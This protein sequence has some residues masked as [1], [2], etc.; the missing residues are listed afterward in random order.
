MSDIEEN[1]CEGCDECNPGI[2][3]ATTAVD[4]IDSL[5][6]GLSANPRYI[7]EGHAWS[8]VQSILGSL[9]SN[10][11]TAGMLAGIDEEKFNEGRKLL[12]D[13]IEDGWEHGEA[14]AVELRVKQQ[15]AQRADDGSDHG[16]H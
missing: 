9:A 15:M 3:A 7:E 16:G 10:M 14:I 1:E 6:F 5:M 2:A 8:F 13:T 11:A 4:V 12:L